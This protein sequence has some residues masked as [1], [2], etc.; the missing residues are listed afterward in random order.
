MLARDGDAL[1][2]REHAERADH[3][4]GHQASEHCRQHRQAVDAF[5]IRI[6]RPHA[7][8]PVVR[9]S[10]ITAGRSRVPDAME[11]ATCNASPPA[12]A[13]PDLGRNT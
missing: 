11:Q 12:Y 2:P 9:R 1:G 4:D 7:S 13:F 5:P 8:P 6:P 10:T 3:E